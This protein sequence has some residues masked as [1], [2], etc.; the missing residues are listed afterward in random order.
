MLDNNNIYINL[1]MSKN[2][3]IYYVTFFNILL[4]YKYFK[5]CYSINFLIFAN[6]IHNFINIYK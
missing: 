2:N 4:Y 5:L 1:F 3:S 6:K